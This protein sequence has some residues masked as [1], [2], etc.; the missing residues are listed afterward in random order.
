VKSLDQ[1]TP[2]LASTSDTPLLNLGAGFVFDT[3]L[4]GLRALARWDGARLTLRN[5]NG[6]SMD[7]SFPDLIGTAYGA[8]AEPCILDGEIVATNG[9]FQDIAQRDKLTDRHRVAA[10]AEARPATFV[11]FDVLV[12]EDGDARHHPYSVRRNTLEAMEI[13][14]RGWATSVVSDSPLLYDAIRARGGEGVIAKRR[15]APYRPGR[16]ADWLKYKSKHS[17]TCVAVGYE[18]GTGSRADFGAMLVALVNGKEAVKVGRVGSG[19]TRREVDRVKA[20]LDAGTMPVVEVECLGLTRD[21]RL[22]Q[23]V[24]KGERTDRT[25]FDAQLSQL[26]SLPIA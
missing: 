3:K 5:R 6:R 26:D 23:P 1:I 18:P 15:L 17:V 8:L 20:L 16:S 12:T 7:A 4:D 19:F 13:S 21:R 22:R 24:Y 2:M 9:A 10:A 14:H 25:I 11:A